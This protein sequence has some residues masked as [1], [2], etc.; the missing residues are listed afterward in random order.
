MQTWLSGIL[1]VGGGTLAAA[2]GLLIVRR[3]VPRDRLAEHE[4]VAGFLIGVVGVFYAVLLGFVILVVWNNYED[5]KARVT[6]AANQLG[7]M[8]HLSEG[9]PDPVQTR[10]RV[11]MAAYGERAIAEE[12]GAMEHGERGPRTEQAVRTFGKFASRSTRRRAARRYC[13]TIC[14]PG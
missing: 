1:M 13:T 5:V 10:L 9:L 14:S 4:E 7:D 3:L 6:Q 11:A 12:W 8:F 2:L